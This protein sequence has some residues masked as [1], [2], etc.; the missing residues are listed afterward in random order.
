[1]KKQFL[2]FSATVLLALGFIACQEKPELAELNSVRMNA[3]KVDDKEAAAYNAD[4]DTVAYA[5]SRL[6]ATNANFRQTVKTEVGKMFDGDYNVLISQ[7]VVNYNFVERLFQEQGVEIRQIVEKYPL[8]QIAIPVNFEKWGGNE[9]LP[10]VYLGA[11]YQEN[12]TEYLYGYTVKGE[13]WKVLEK[14]EPDFPVV[15]ISENERTKIIAG[16]PDELVPSAPQSLAATTTAVGIKLT[17]LKPTSGTIS[18]YDVYRKGVGEA[19]Y[20]VIYTL[21]GE[22]NLHFEDVSISPE[23]NYSYYVTAFYEEIAGRFRIYNSAPFNLIP[24]LTN[25][26]KHSSPPSN[27]VTANSPAL[28]VPAGIRLEHGNAKQLDLEWNMQTAYT[29]SF[30]VW[31]KST[32][33]TDYTLQGTTSNVDNFFTQSNLSAGVF[34]RYKVRA[35]TLGGSYSGWSQSIATSASERNVETPFKLTMLKFKN[36]EALKKVESWSRGAPELWLTVVKGDDSNSA[37]KFKTI[38]YEPSNREASYS[39]WNNVNKIILNN[40]NPNRDGTVF[41]FVWIEEDANL[42]GSSMKITASYEN[43]LD[44]NQ[45]IKLGAEV[46][47]NFSDLDDRMG[48]SIITW[49]NPKSTEFEVYPDFYWKIE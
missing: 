6:L 26:D 5:V 8:I 48:N 1:M 30:E 17:W 7:L 34:Y 44:E 31:R 46:T 37:T 41:T 9:G 42:K 49:W 29:N 19:N 43:K 11:D 10:T 32:L 28:A 23:L 13:R 35:K 16:D 20:S 4:F 24:R 45:T 47:I 38:R 3:P 18:G 12:V 2:V 36:K 33:D 22:D 15:V 27:Y 21:H 14:V 25:D 39:S 40:W